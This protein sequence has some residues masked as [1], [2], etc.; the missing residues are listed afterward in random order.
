M[1]YENEQATPPPTPE[2]GPDPLTQQVGN[3]T[4]EV[5][6][7][8]EEQA[9]RDSRNYPPA[10]PSAAPEVKAPTTLLIYR[11]GHQMEVQDYAILGKTLWVLSDQTTRR[12]ALADLDLTATWR[13]NAE[14]GVDFITPNSQ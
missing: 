13:V 4:A 1:G 2:Q 7:M 6:M 14:R 9:M 8:R 3:L 12:V 11:D 10:E 5:E